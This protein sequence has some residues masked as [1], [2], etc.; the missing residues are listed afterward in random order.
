MKTKVIEVRLPEYHLKKKPD[1]VKLGKEVDEVI[2]KS[3]PDG[4]YILR[5]L[6][7]DDHPNLSLN[8]LAEIILKTETDRYDSNRKGLCHD[9]FCRIFVI[10][11][12]D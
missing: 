3:F 9:E 6:G 7:S 4:K 10:F 5:A 2:E 12:N 8:E 1:Y 11:W